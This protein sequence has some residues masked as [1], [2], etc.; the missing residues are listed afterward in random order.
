MPVLRGPGARRRSTSR[1][2]YP[3]VV[4]ANIAK[5]LYRDGGGDLRHV[6]DASCGPG[7]HR[8]GF[9]RLKDAGNPRD[10]GE[11]PKPLNPRGRTSSVVRAILE[12]TSLHPALPCCSSSFGLVGSPACGP[13]TGPLS[14]P[15]PSR[16]PWSLPSC[17]ARQN[18]RSGSN[19]SPSCLPRSGSRG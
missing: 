3:R 1:A 14:P 12:D 2:L 16:P 5:I 8:L 4:T 9:A 17:R 11:L 13:S 15:A 7:S 6:R 18:I 19:G 10:G